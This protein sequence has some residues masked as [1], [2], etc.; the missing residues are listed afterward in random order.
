MQDYKKNKIRSLH[1]VGIKGVGMAPLA[2]IAKEAGFVVSGCDVADEFITDE[3]L[4]KAGIFSSVGFWPS[5]LTSGKTNIDLVITTGAHGGFDNPEVASAK[6]LNIPIWT[7][8]QAVG[9]FMQGEIFGKSQVGVSVAGSHG[10]TTTTAML[11]TI[12]K[13]AKRDP[14]FVIGTGNVSSLGSCGHFGSGKYFIAEADEYATE[15]TYDKTPKFLWQHPEIAIFTNIELDHPDL[16]PTID[17]IREAFLQFANNLGPSGLLI[18]YGGDIQISKLLK[19]YKGK[20]LTY[21]FI[22]DNDFV[23]SRIYPSDGQTFFHLSAHGHELGEFILSIAGEHNV[24][25]ATAAII[26]ALELGLSIESIKNG[27]KLYVGSKRRFEFIGELESGALLYDDYAHHPTEIKKTLAAF[28]KRF[29]K[30]KIVC[31]FQPHT[32]SRTKTLFDQFISSF[33]DVDTVIISNIYPS[34][35]ETPDPAV[36]SELFVEAMRKFHGNA[37]FLP[38]SSDVIK[39]INSQNFGQDTVVITMGAGDIYKIKDQ[40]SNIKFQN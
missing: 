16:Y 14:S 36:S 18:A 27:L 39:Y 21:G 35:R 2:I 8:G 29:P 20:H 5:H 38:G 40:I 30:H 11:A 13:N 34:M 6:D 24:L 25:N 31:V 9:E 15:P 37:I 3:S 28:K 32:Y 7:Q 4:N 1:F 23:I 12:L 22:G 10:K 26:A 33:S 19:E 17:S